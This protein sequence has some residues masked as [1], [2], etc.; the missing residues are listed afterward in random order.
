MPCRI[1]PEILRYIELVEADTP[2][3]CEEQHALVDYIRRCFETEDIYVDTVQL[4]K[5]LGMARYYPFER[6]F[7]WEEFLI[8]PCDCTSTATGLPR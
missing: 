6:L 8:A 3:A 4:E 2:R 1:Q 7:P 5:Y